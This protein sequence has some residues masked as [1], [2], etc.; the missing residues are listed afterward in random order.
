MTQ[1]ALIENV[2]V[3][4]PVSNSD[5][6]ATVWI[7]NGKVEAIN[8]DPT[9]EIP[10]TAEVIDGQG[11]ILGPALVDLHST[12]SDP[13]YESRE[14]LAEFLAAATAGG[15]GHVAV[16]PHTEPEIA[17][18]AQ[19]YELNQR[20]QTLQSDHPHLAKCLPWSSA[21]VDRAGKQFTELGELRPAGA[22]GFTDAQPAT[23]L[24]LCRRL[25]EYAAPLNCAIALWPWNPTLAG[26]GHLFEGPE[27]LRGGLIKIPVAAEAAAVA[28]VLELSDVHTA[29][30]HLMRIGSDRA[31]QLI[32]QGKTRDAKITASTTWLSLVAHSGH[33]T[34][35]TNLVG[36]D[37]PAAPYDSNFH[38]YPPLPHPRQ[39][40]EL[41]RGI[42]DGTLD[43]IAID[44]HAYTY[45]EKTVAFGEAPVGTLGYGLALP[46]LW[47]ALV[48]TGDLTA[49]DL[50]RALTTGPAG[51]LGVEI[52]AIAPGNPADLILFNP[53]EPWTVTSENLKTQAANTP[54]LNRTIPGTIVKQW[55]SP[56]PPS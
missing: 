23:D 47:Q 27:T 24:V 30:L 43:A 41:I 3:V 32:R 50:W 49:L 2:R 48:E 55:R 52:K 46:L 18:P 14:T 25:L 39:R 12:L 28:S 6:Q 13:G 36:S 7:A 44:H 17:T 53:A 35:E 16:L 5:R 31:V 56:Q 8:P 45:E 40:D 42:K 34:G 11:C 15:F 26:G 4:D 54:W 21:T 51:V 29:P 10:E 38:C 22:I 1:D 20:V 19:I 9:A 33:I 37:S